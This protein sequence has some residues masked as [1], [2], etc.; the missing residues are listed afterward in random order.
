MKLP[1]LLAIAGVLGLGTTLLFG[2]NLR[3]SGSDR[4]QTT[5]YASG[6]LESRVEYQDGRRAG[7]AERWYADGARQS[8]G[9]YVD[10]RME[11]DWQ[12]WN[13]DGSVDPQRTGSYRAGDRVGEPSVGGS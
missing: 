1:S 4:S 7:L 3:S 10:G 8:A 2:A 9:R 5:Y 11:G 13:P 6:Q 12:F